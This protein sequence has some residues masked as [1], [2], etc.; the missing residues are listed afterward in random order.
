MAGAERVEERQRVRRILRADRALKGIDLRLLGGGARPE[1]KQRRGTDAERHQG[2][3][4]CG[5]RSPCH[6]CAPRDAAILPVVAYPTAFLVRPSWKGT[7]GA[8][9]VQLSVCDNILI[10]CGNKLAHASRH[11]R[12]NAV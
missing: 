5:P 7:H 3:V 2:S 11:D 1:R 8:D 10:N 6:G 4:N 9:R 12:G